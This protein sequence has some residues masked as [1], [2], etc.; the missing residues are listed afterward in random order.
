MLKEVLPSTILVNA[1]FLYVVITGSVLKPHV[2][3]LIYNLGPCALDEIFF[4]YSSTSSKA[5]GS[6]FKLKF[7]GQARFGEVDDICKDSYGKGSQRSSFSQRDPE[8]GLL[9]GALDFL[10]I[11]SIS[12]R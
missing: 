8:Y 9:R 5:I 11:R 10:N 2:I 4:P 12:Q 1:L 3:I 6:C 7:N